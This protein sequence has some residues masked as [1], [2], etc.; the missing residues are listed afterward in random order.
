MLNSIENNPHNCAVIVPLIESA[1]GFGPL[2]QICA[3]PKVERLMFG[4]LNF[5][6][7]MQMRGTG[8]EPLYFRSQLTLAARL[9]GIVFP[10]DGVTTTIDDVESI[11]W[12]TTAARNL[13]FGGKL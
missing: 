10:V 6:V 8:I 4:N 2:P 11:H 3:A 7:D 1:T 13:G 12:E 9:R 5:Q